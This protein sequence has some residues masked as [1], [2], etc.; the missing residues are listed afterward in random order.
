M[1]TVVK[2]KKDKDSELF[3]MKNFNLGF[4]GNYLFYKTHNYSNPEHCFDSDKLKYQ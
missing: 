3:Y 2:N 4:V 1:N